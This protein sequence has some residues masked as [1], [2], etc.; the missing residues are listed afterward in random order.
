MHVE[1]NWRHIECKSPQKICSWMLRK[2]NFVVQFEQNNIRVFF[3][4]S[5]SVNS[6]HPALNHSV[7]PVVLWGGWAY[8]A[9]CWRC[10]PLMTASLSVLFVGSSSF[11]GDWLMC[12]FLPPDSGLG[13]SSGWASPFLLSSPSLFRLLT[14]PQLSS[15]RR[16]SGTPRTRRHTMAA[17][18]S[19]NFFDFSL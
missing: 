6:S 11:W 12:L 1:G 4:L 15:P 18:C 16:P 17:A 7:R 19:A 9:V 2:Y 10:E 5:W 8:D 3:F 13:L 14:S